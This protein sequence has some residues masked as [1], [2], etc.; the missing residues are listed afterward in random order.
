MVQ[1]IEGVLLGTSKKF[2]CNVG[3]YHLEIAEEKYFR[4]TLANENVELKSIKG[5]V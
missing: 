3:T 2:W 5:I 1:S 4:L